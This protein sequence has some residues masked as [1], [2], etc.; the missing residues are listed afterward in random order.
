M[1]EE[2]FGQIGNFTPA[3]VAGLG[4]TLGIQH[5]FEADHIA[6]VCTQ[7]TN[8]NKIQSK[9]QLFKAS[10]TKSSLLGA[11]WGSSFFNIKIAT[12]SFQPYTLALIRVIFAT[13]FLM[14]FSFFFSGESP[15]GYICVKS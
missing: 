13:L 12:Y 2:I 7:L 15:E 10:L 5:A 6:A 3:I 8:S 1:L 14:I 11:I 9:K 4:L